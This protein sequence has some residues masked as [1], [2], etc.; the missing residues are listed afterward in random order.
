MHDYASAEDLANYLLYLDRNRTAYN[1]YFEWKQYVSFNMSE[2]RF[3]GFPGVFCDMCIKLHMERFTG[4]QNKVFDNIQNY[5]HY[6][7]CKS[8]NLNAKQ[9]KFSI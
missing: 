3:S 5:W 8:G 9:I 4:I 6:E 7:N 1:S 2:S